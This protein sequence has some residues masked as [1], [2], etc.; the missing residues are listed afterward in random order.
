V[1]RKGIGQKNCG[2]G[3]KEEEPFVGYQLSARGVTWGGEGGNLETGLKKGKTKRGKEDTTDKKNLGRP[4]K[5]GKK[6]KDKNDPAKTR[7]KMCQGT[8]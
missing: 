7:P 2:K 4:G 3:D 6:K 5:T 8:R 1:A